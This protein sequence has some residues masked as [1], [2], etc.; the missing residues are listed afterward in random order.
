MLDAVVMRCLAGEP[1]RRYATASDLAAALAECQAALGQGAAA[2]SP[3]AGSIDGAAR[4][5]LRAAALRTLTRRVRRA[6]I[7]NR[8]NTA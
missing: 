6:A 1:A 3:R 5:R 8:K 4:G 2:T 7:D